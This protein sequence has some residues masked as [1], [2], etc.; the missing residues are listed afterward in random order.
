[1]LKPTVISKH[2]ELQEGCY[3]R[4]MLFDLSI[5]GHH[6]GYIR[7]LVEHW[8]LRN[9]PGDLYLVVSPA[10]FKEH[11]DVVQLARRH[12]DQRV[13]FISISTQEYAALK[14]RDFKLSRV[15]RHFQEWKLLCKYASALNANHCLVMY[16]D[17]YYL[18]IILGSSPPCTFS[19]IYFR[20]TFHYPQFSEYRGTL[21]DRFFQLCEKSILLQA[22]K[23][24]RFSSVLSLD[25]FVVEYMHKVHPAVSITHLP[26][27]IQLNLFVQTSSQHRLNSLGVDPARKVFLLFGSLNGRKGIYQLLDA[28]MLLTDSICEKICL[29]LVGESSVAEKLDSKIASVVQA[30]PVQIITDYEFVPEEEVIEYFQLAD[31]V[32]AP[33]QHHVGMSGILLLAAA[34]GKPVLSSNYGLMGE[35]VKRYQL[36]VVVD[37][38]IPEEISKGLSHLLQAAPGVLFDQA[39]ARC[40]A[41]HNSV[42]RFAQIIFD[43]AYSASGC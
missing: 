40:F 32:L 5:R 4:L 8:C 15:Q 36:G 29:L 12:K 33:Y 39:K 21:R 20:P 31:F 2:E 1:M 38:T 34:A 26:D 23:H 27:P 43:E 22:T 13:K 10:F 25:P 37:S 7:H 28:L 3:L 24:S 18:P 11:V 9:N 6:P 17:T 16:L 14:P 35:L 41:E 19:G 30:K 42:D